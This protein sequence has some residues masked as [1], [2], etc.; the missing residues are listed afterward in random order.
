MEPASNDPTGEKGPIGSEASVLVTGAAGFIGVSVVEN[1]LARQFRNVRCLVRETSDLTRL[2]RLLERNQETRIEVLM[3]NLLSPADCQKLTQDAAVIYHLAAGTG[4]KAFS[5]AF[6][7]SVV[8]TRN[9]LQAAV[10]SRSLKRFVN[11]SSFSVYPNRGGRR[12]RLLDE[13]SPVERHPESRAEAYCYGK[14]KQDELVVDYG[15]RLG[16]PYVIVRPGSV[17]GPGRCIIPGRIGIDTFG[18]FL[19]LGGP[20]AIPFTYVENCADAIVL[21]GLVPGIEGQVFNIVDDDLPSSGRFLRLYKKN[22]KPFP[23]VYMPHA[24]SYTFCVLWEILSRWSRGQVPPVF[25]RREWAASWKRT[26]YSNSK[27]KDLTGWSPRVSTSEGMEKF[28]ASCRETVA[29]QDVRSSPV[30]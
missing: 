27:L 20:N 9:L 23:S 22:V 10:L 2:R 6:L 18:F 7:H 29:T 24:V 25:T 21:A 4:T 16:V 19:H 12:W 11:V 14:V 28:F 5:E 3:G 8:G 15:R 13:E 1:L 26:R 17:Y 30:D